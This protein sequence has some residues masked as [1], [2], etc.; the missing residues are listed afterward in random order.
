MLTDNFKKLNLN[1]IEFMKFTVPFTIFNAINANQSSKPKVI[2]YKN[3]KFNSVFPEIIVNEETFEAQE[4]RAA[5]G[6]WW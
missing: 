4:D 6:H 1:R 3:I 2:R 5:S